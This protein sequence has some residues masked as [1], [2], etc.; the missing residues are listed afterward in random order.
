MSTLEGGAGKRVDPLPSDAERQIRDSFIYLLPLVVSNLLPFLTLPIFTRI[1]TREDYGILALAQVYAVFVGGI[2]NF[3]MNAAY[4]RNYFQY[5]ENPKDSG[6]LLFSSLLFVLF[7]TTVLGIPTYCYREALSAWMIGSPGHGNILFWAFLNQCAMNL[8]I[9]YQ[10]SLR[11]AGE[12]VPYLRYTVAIS[13]LNLL[14]SL[15]FV[16]V[17]RIGVIGLVYAPLIAN[18]MIFSLLSRRYVK[19]WSFTLSWPLFLESLK[20]S[21]PLTPRIFLGAASQQ[22]DKYMIGLLSTLGGVG[23]YRIGQQVASLTFSY[24]TQL[25][26]VFIPQTYRHMFDEQGT[27]REATGSY[28]TPFFYVSIAV[29]FLICLFSEEVITLLTPPAFH[30][31]IDIVTIL[32]LYYGIL[33]FAKITGIQLIYLKKT[34]ITSLL[35]L[36]AL[37]LNVAINIP[38]ILKWGAI[39]AAWG[40]MLAGVVSC[41][42][43]FS[44]AQHY[45]GIRWEYG[46]ILPVLVLFFSAALLTVALRN[47]VEY[48][49][50]LLLKLLLA[51]AY[52]YV[53][54]WIR[55]LT[56]ENIGHLRNLLRL[57]NRI[58]AQR[59]G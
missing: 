2:A 10:L 35:T 55:V 28:L 17:A 47:H 3:G 46:K 45:Y 9:F 53:G 6:G 4:E 57:R 58:V 44:V 21:Y 40:T 56:A 39:G 12:S 29:A 49:Q 36:S 32:S 23:V 51:G 22:F 7:S 20:I 38:F 26:H 52:V 27:G 41:A 1:L 31:A 8:V 34:H 42:V 14:L 33:F 59:N 43:S 13:L 30:D 48:P 50:R 24:M 16:V 19:A 54:V 25:E 37:A 5:R 18:G 15:Y 11:N